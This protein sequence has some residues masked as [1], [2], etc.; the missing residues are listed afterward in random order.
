M[1]PLPIKKGTTSDR[2][3]CGACPHDDRRSAALCSPQ[4]SRRQSRT[5]C[6]RFSLRKGKA[7]ATNRAISTSAARSNG[8][9]RSPQQNSPAGSG[10]NTPDGHSQ[11][12]GVNSLRAAFA[13]TALATASRS[14]GSVMQPAPRALA[15]SNNSSSSSL[16][17]AFQGTMGQVR[18]SLRHA[19][20]T[21]GQPR[22]TLQR[23]EAEDRS[24]LKWT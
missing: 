4:T 18:C 21:V 6:G 23:L 16:R 17:A 20:G 5:R 2:A 10:A 11:S 22:P 1:S 13:P 3:Q 7:T 24:P 12:A 15:R 8:A 14:R 9:T 19:L